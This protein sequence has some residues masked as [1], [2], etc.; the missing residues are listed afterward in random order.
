METK[1]NYISTKQPKEKKSNQGLKQTEVIKVTIASTGDSVE[2]SSTDQ[3][4][5]PLQALFQ[6]KADREQ[7][8]DID[9]VSFVEGEVIV[10]S[11]K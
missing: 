6:E 7:H 9:G 3:C 5:C 4:D 2:L 10:A 11:S 8:Y 1:K